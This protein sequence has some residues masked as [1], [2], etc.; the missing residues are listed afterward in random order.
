M[1]SMT[2]IETGDAETVRRRAS[3]TLGAL[4]SHRGD[5]RPQPI[6]EVGIKKHE[7]R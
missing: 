6:A 3:R 5:Q 1:V 2:E 7:S 4:A